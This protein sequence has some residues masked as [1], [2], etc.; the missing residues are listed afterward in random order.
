MLYYVRSKSDIRS[1]IAMAKA[2]FGKKKALFTRKLGLNLKSKLLK[3]F[4]CSIALY[5]AE[6]WAIRKVDQK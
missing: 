3:C 4:I 5:G 1:K 6:T 2:A